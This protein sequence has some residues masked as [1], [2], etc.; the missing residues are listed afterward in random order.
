MV[1][2]WRATYET[3]EFLENVSHILFSEEKTV[4]RLVQEQE[5]IKKH[6]VEASWLTI[7]KKLYRDFIYTREDSIKEFTRDYGKD[8]HTLVYLP[9]LV[10]LPNSHLQRL[11]F[12]IPGD[13]IT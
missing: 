5:L 7:G 4:T 10:Y 3:R 1:I 9:K 8:T 13:A 2:H 6:G 11:Y 12:F